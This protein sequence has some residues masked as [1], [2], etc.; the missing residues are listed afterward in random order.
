[1]AVFIYLFSLLTALLARTVLSQA[2]AL[3]LADGYSSFS[4]DKFVGKLVKSS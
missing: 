1:M 4:N 2:D 3:G